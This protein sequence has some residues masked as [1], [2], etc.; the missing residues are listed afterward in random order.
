MSV[1]LDLAPRGDL[2]RRAFLRLSLAA[3][4]AGV[5]PGLLTGC[6]ADPVTGRSTL[7]GLD[8]RQEVALDREY[9]PHQFSADYG[10]VQDDKLNRYVAEVG[11]SEWS[12]SHRPQMPYSAR[13]VNANYINA[14]TFPGGSMAVT[15][16]IMLELQSEDELAALLGHEIGH[17]N[18]RHA[19]ERAG[20]DMVAQYG[21]MAAQIG[22]SVAGLGEYGSIAAQITQVGSSALLASYSRDDEREADALGMEYMTRAGYNAEGMVGLMDILRKEGHE[23]PSMI[24]TMFSSHPMSDE[25]YATAQR[26]AASKYAASR[27]ARVKRER[28]MD[29]TAG[30]RAAAPAVRAEQ[31]GETLLAA[32]KMADAEREYA[33][34]LKLAPNDYTGLVLMT[35]LKLAQKQYAQAE[36]FV[37][38]AVAVYPSE[39]QAL[40]LGGLVKLAQKKPDLALQ[41]FEA[42]D[43]VLPGNPNASFFKGVSLDA[44][45]RRKEATQ[46]YVQFLKSG[47]QGPQAQHAYTR[48]KEWGVAR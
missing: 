4:G 41:R 32:G 34:A 17:V 23:R 44:M 37:D 26:T 27:S 21:S 47:G 43:K 10:A 33:S 36:P 14:Y 38:R 16:G 18:A 20:R 31:R 13:T 8:E 24:E 29:S 3:A 46:Q 40:K 25:R 9:A 5:A 39:G 7:V 42:Y 6:A 19:A 1:P 2:S 11:A 30:L 15:R 45:Q 35:Q 28:Y 48:L 22:L 12:R